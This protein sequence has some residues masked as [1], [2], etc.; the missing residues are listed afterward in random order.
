MKTFLHK[1][2]VKLLISVNL[3]IMLTASLM[4]VRLERENHLFFK[5]M[6][7]AELKGRRYYFGKPEADFTQVEKKLRQE[8]DSEI[9]NF[10]QTIT[11]Q[12]YYQRKAYLDKPIVFDLL[13]PTP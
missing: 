4:I 11:K 1:H 5:K 13:E 10:T 6:I 2:S 9:K 8:W 12:E 7:E 3:L